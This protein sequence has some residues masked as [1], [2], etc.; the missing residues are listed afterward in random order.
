MR[1]EIRETILQTSLDLFNRHGFSSVSLRQI[2]AAIGIS[3]GNLCYHFKNKEKI[4]LALFQGLARHMEATYEVKDSGL[5]TLR[6]ILSGFSR[7]HLEYRFFFL[8]IT[9]LLERHPLL[10]K[11]FLKI[12][13]ARLEQIRG[14]CSGLVALGSLVSEPLPGLYDRLV[15]CA[16]FVGMFWMSGFSLSEEKSPKIFAEQGIERT[17]LLFYPYLSGKGR[18]EFLAAMEEGGFLGR[19]E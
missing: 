4:L 7:C 16:W 1:K 10:K 11:S 5:T 3:H 15:E 8:D 18:K 19:R 6:A 17:L 9:G 14:L 12:Q 13:K 2:A